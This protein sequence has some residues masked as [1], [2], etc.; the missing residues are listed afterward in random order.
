MNES[1]LIRGHQELRRIRLVFLTSVLDSLGGSEKNIW[2]LVRNLP[3][4]RFQSYVLALKGGATLRE[5]AK[6]GIYAED[7]AMDS[8]LSPRGI[9]KAFKLLR[10]FR[11]EKI[12]IL[13]TYH[14]DADI[15]GGLLG[16]LAGIPVIISNKLDMGYQVSWKLS[17]LYGYVNWCFTRFIAV[18]NGVK[19]RIAKAQMIPLSRIEVIYNGTEIPDIVPIKRTHYLHTLLRLPEH[20]RLVGMVASFRAIK[21]HEYFVRAAA[22]ITQQYEDVDFI[23]I[24]YT[25]TDYYTKISALIAELGLHAKVHCMGHRKDIRALLQSLDIFVLSSLHEGFSNAILEAMAEGLP[26]IASRRGGNPEIVTTENGILVEPGDVDMLAAA[27]T[28]LLANRTVR[29]EMGR[30]GLELVRNQF[31]LSRAVSHYQDL[32][33]SELKMKTSRRVTLYKHG[34]RGA[35]SSAES[36]Q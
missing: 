13:M 31:S 7:L 20:Q 16:S 25:G 28:R 2:D 23:I 21:G 10:F 11:N 4:T 29:Q 9:L 14:E 27:I 8:I 17:L 12:D 26:V 18:S 34:T 3:A 5:I 22:K 33:L 32:L 30:R 1:Q 36:G 19:E 15:V 6:L 24:G 35:R